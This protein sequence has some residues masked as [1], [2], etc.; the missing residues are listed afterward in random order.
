MNKITLTERGKAILTQNSLQGGEVY[1]VGYFGLAYVP[2]QKNFSPASTRLIGD[3]ESGDYI[4]NLWQGDLVNEGHS[5]QGDLGGNGYSGVAKTLSKL[6]LYDRN[7]TS[8]FRYMYDEENDRNRLVTWVSEQDESSVTASPETSS[9]VR[10]G[11][12]VYNG[13]TMGDSHNTDDLVSESELPCPAPL[14]YAG[15]TA[16]YS[17]PSASPADFMHSVISNDW[18][19]LETTSGKCPFVTPDM[20][21]YGGSWKGGSTGSAW[22]WIPDSAGKYDTLPAENTRKTAGGGDA[23]DGAEGLDQYAKFISVSNFNKDHGH[24]SSEGYGVGYQESCHNMS[25]VTRLFPIANYEL[26]ATSDP[27]TTDKN[28]T[29]RG[30]AKSIK[31]VIGLNLKAAYQGVKTY[32]DTLNYQKSVTAGVSADELALYTSTKPNSFKFNRIGIYAVRTTIRHFYK[33]T[34]AANHTDCRATHYQMEISPDAKPE[35]FAVMQVDEVCMSEDGSFGLGNYNTTF[36]LNLENTPETTG[37]CT[38]PEVYY[39]LAE[40]EAITWYQ[41]QLIA[42]A[43]LSEAVTNLGVN[44]AYLMSNMGKGDAVACYSGNPETVLSE[45]YTGLKNLVDDSFG[46]GSVRDILS[47]SQD[48]PLPALNKYAGAWS[49]GVLS[50]T[51]GDR[52]ATLGDYSFNMTVNGAIDEDVDHV[53]LMGGP[54]ASSDATTQYLTVQDSSYSIIM[55]TVGDYHEVTNSLILGGDEEN[56]TETVLGASNSLVFG[57]GNMGSKTKFV[58]SIVNGIGDSIVEYD[59]ITYTYPESIQSSL[60]LGKARLLGTIGQSASGWTSKDVY[61]L[62]LKNIFLMTGDIE[63]PNGIEARWIGHDGISGGWYDA[64]GRPSVPDAIRS[65]ADA[66]GQ[67]YNSPM[68]FT[69]GLALGGHL[70]DSSE[71][72]YARNQIDYH[73]LPGT[74]GLLKLGTAYRT[75]GSDTYVDPNATWPARKNHHLYMN[76]PSTTVMITG[77]PLRVYR[78]GTGE[79]LYPYYV[80]GATEDDA[81]IVKVYANHIGGAGHN[82]DHWLVHSPHAGKPLIATEMQELDGTLHI[83]LGQDYMHGNSGGITRVECSYLSGTFKLKITYQDDPMYYIH[84]IRDDEHTDETPRYATYKVGYDENALVDAVVEDGDYCMHDAS[85]IALR[86]KYHYVV[87]PG[88][89]PEIDDS[90]DMVIDELSVRVETSRPNIH[91]FYGSA[92][93]ATYVKYGT[94]GDG[95]PIYPIIHMSPCFDISDTNCFVSSAWNLFGQSKRLLQ[96]TAPYLAYS[97]NDGISTIGVN[98]NAIVE[99]ERKALYRFSASNYRTHRAER[100]SASIIPLRMEKIPV[101]AEFDLVDVDATVYIPPNT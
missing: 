55:G 60:W 90:Y 54:A 78:G 98:S 52:N 6:T 4:Y 36:V 66:F 58:N 80:G 76:N 8:N 101:T 68:I 30:S 31:Y 99:L 16:S 83:G 44:V 92:T 64:M 94:D 87:H 37:I 77:G 25:M 26:T 39:N 100:P 53:L 89:D 33:E 93:D 18:P 12:R 84:V 65:Q 69:G 97:G 19:M 48:M 27:A 24:V 86:F 62:P 49:C 43:G 75:Y 29:E 5:I 57:V 1:W 67:T 34:D 96:F 40:N 13:V 46:Q 81:D 22:D 28:I 42:T 50:F 20:R 14:F 7:I 73:C 9:Y 95:N 70:S 85:G 15:G 41:N 2:D 56:P 45:S 47:A 79:G 82:S 11:Y 88:T 61:E 23:S 63:I 32:L 71:T 72:C 17:R 10:D 74:Y 51:M 59:G 35:L 3:N 21:F 91:T 38:N